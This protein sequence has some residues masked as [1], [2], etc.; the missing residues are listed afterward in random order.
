MEEVSWLDG[1]R[2]SAKENHPCNAEDTLRLIA[3]IEILE[4]KILQQS[5]L[6]KSA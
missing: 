6:P 4:V 1:L 5:A 3:E 2:K